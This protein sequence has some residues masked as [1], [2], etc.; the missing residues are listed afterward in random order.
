MPNCEAKKFP[1]NCPTTDFARHELR[2]HFINM[3]LCCW[4]WS[5]SSDIKLH[6]SGQTGPLQMRPLMLSPLATSVEPCSS[7]LIFRERHLSPVQHSTA[8]TCYRQ[9]GLCTKPPSCSLQTMPTHRSYYRYCWNKILS[10][11]GRK[12]TDG[13]TLTLHMFHPSTPFFFPV[14]YCLGIKK[15]QTL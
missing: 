10:P 2:I 9:S 4:H 8:V 11:G 7:P 14:P 5:V 3:A 6:C 12:A 1:L 15:S 13:V